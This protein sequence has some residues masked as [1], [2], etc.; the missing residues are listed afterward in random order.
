MKQ[1]LIRMSLMLLCLFLAGYC[2]L[3][4]PVRYG[5]WRMMQR[6]LAS[7]QTASRFGHIGKSKVAM[8]C[9]NSMT[10]QLEQFLQSKRPCKSGYNLIRKVFN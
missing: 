6:F 1:K 7:C 2:F 3:R 5:L 10:W 9:F 8:H 4:E